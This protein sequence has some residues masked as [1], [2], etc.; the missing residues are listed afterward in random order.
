MISADALAGLGP[1]FAAQ[2]GELLAPLVEAMTAPGEIAAESLELAGSGWA[3]ML[4][5]H[6]AADLVWLAQLTGA[7]LD[8]GNPAQQR[9]QLLA[10]EAWSRG[11]VRALRASLETAL[12]GLKRVLISER[13]DNPWRTSIRV[14]ESELPPG[15]TIDDIAAI[16]ERN[17]PAGITFSC[18]VITEESYASVEVSAETYAAAEASAGTYATA[19]P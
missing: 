10:H 18:A 11:T 13:E 2:A 6:K 3:A 19:E 7:T 9:A 12:T 8:P 14:Y 4:D 16:A 17:R 5:V 1:T 15:T